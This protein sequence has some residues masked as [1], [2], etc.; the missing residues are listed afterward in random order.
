MT[1]AEQ[2]RE[3]LARRRREGAVFGRAWSDTF[4]EIDW[5]GP[6][7]VGKDWRAAYEA[8][9]PGALAAQVEQLRELREWG[10]H[11]P[12]ERVAALG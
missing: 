6:K 11:R 1:P 5:P 10:E 9:P 3:G 7:H 8:Q 4:S 12:V 2:L